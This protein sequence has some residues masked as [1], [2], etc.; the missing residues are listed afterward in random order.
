MRY[1]T[2]TPRTQRTNIPLTFGC[3][4][5]QPCRR[6]ETP[7]QPQRFLGRFPVPCSL[8]TV[9]IPS[10]PKPD[11]FPDRFISYPPFVPPSDTILQPFSP[12]GS[13]AGA[14]AGPDACACQIGDGGSELGRIRC[15]IGL[16]LESYVARAS[17]IRSGLV[18][19]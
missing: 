8:F 14:F 4:V 16:G 1:A 5:D 6:K 10:Q 17:G 9:T 13:C 3:P 11:S 19:C 7:R 12:A 15:R 2:T 18:V